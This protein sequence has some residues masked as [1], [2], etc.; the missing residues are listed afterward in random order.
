MIQNHKIEYVQTLLRKNYLGYREIAKLV[1]VS[2]GTVGKIASGQLTVSTSV[3]SLKQSK[4]FERC[5]ECGGRVLMPCRACDLKKRKSHE[6][7]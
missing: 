7:H 5:P 1:G 4:D 3:Y 6:L 2:R